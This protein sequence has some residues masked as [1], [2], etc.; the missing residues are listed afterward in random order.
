MRDTPSTRRSW[1]SIP[2]PRRTATSSAGSRHGSESASLSLLRVS[3]A[4]QLRRVPAQ[5][6]RPILRRE[7]GDLRPDKGQ[8]VF[9]RGAVGLGPGGTGE[10]GAPE[11][12]VGTERLVDRLDQ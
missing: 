1:T 11:Q 6:L 12:A 7:E 5:D 8:L 10:A 9:E 4:P 2:P 3:E